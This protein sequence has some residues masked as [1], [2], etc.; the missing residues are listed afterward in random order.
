MWGHVVCGWVSLALRSIVRLSDG[1]HMLVLFNTE[2]IE[3]PTA[4]LMCLYIVEAT[5]VYRHTGVAVEWDC[6]MLVVE[7]LN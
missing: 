5:T 6:N 2:A 7:T 3:V 4:C 1:L